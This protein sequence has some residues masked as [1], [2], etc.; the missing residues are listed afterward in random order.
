M[1]RAKIVLILIFVAGALVR[2]ADVMRPIDKPS[3]RECD[4]GSISRNFVQEGFNPF[5]PRIDWRGNTEGYTEMEFPL[6][7]ALIAG[8]YKVFGVHDF[9]GRAWAFLFSLGAMFFFFRLARYYLD[10]FFAIF[11]ALFFA[12][13]PLIV[14]ISTSIQPEGLMMFTY[15]AAAWFFINWLDNEKSKYF[16]LA[17]GFTALTLLA[18]ATA[19]HIGLFFGLLLVQKYGVGVFRQ[20]R[21]WIFGAIS[22][23]PCLLWYLHGKGLWKTYGNSLGVSNEY[24][25]IG[26]DF[27]TNPYFLK[28]ILRLELVYVWALFGLIVGAFAL[29][30]GWRERAFRH[31]ALWLGSVFLMYLVAARTAADDW[32]SYY[33]VFSVPAV[34]LIFGFGI[35]KLWEYMCRS[36]DHFNDFSLP[37]NFLKLGLILVVALSAG[38][39]LLYEA[40]YVRAN[41]LEKHRADESFACASELK[42]RLEK[43]GLILVSGGNCLDPD[44]YPLAFNSSFMFYWLE[45]KGFNICIEDQSVAKVE[46]YAKRGAVYFVAAKP[47]LKAR[48]EFEA[49]LRD[50]FTVAAECGEFLV[51]DLTAG[52]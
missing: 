17:V 1:S 3:W 6:Y 25:W 50:R 36:A 51:F 44:G 2:V 16:W 15:I 32:A 29:W 42:P 52:K 23:A 37:R 10:D 45:R 7:P 49:G 20:A 39:A 47:G 34:A 5:Y 48:P 31:A 26:L 9:I 13:N 27:F 4:L 24:H 12:F 22:L 11:A 30:R 19:G 8:T 38:S 33:H 35:K 28:G 41:F 18:K 14:D 46:E 21:V 43:P 40:V